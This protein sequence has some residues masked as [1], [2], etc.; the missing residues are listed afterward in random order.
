MGPKVQAA[1]QF[2]IGSGKQAAIGRLEDA[3]QI[4]EGTAGTQVRLSTNS[5]RNI[6]DQKFG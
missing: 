3:G 1:C 5:V 2:V 4:V 6:E